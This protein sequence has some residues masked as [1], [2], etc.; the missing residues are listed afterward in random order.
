MVYGG[1][2]ATP[3]EGYHPAEYAISL[4]D[5]PAGTDAASET[6]LGPSGH[7]VMRGHIDG[8]IPTAL[9][10][11]LLYPSPRARSLALYTSV[12][13]IAFDLVPSRC[14]R[15]GYHLDPSLRPIEPEGSRTPPEF[16][17]DSDP[18][19]SS[20]PGL[21]AVAP[22]S[23]PL[24]ISAVARSPVGP[25]VAVTPA[26]RSGTTWEFA[27]ESFYLFGPGGSAGLSADRALGSISTARIDPRPV[28][29]GRAVAAVPGGVAVIAGGDAV[30]LSGSRATTILA[31]TGG[32]LLGYEPA[33][34]ELWCARASPDGDAPAAVRVVDMAR[35]WNYLRD[36][37]VPT[38]FC[39]TAAGLLATMDGGAVRD[40]SVGTDGPMEISFGLDAQVGVRRHAR[41]P[42][43]L[44]MAGRSL[45]GTVNV[46]ASQGGAQS[47][48]VATFG[49]DGDLD[50]PI[51]AMLALPHCH[52]LRVEARLTTPYPESFTLTLE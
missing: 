41:V 35:D 19:P 46:A 34:R 29:S 15:W 3:F 51:G 27:R 49:L 1:L 14:G 8:R 9:S 17:D 20:W 28:L 21:V 44:A 45:A 30:R 38:S 50:H 40:C 39:A 7:T 47:V 6:D 2:T 31:G 13:H 16:P 43:G 11:L 48:D 22:V 12:W 42:F 26:A 18:L 52:A 10:P 32:D 36:D 5:H 4:A 23:A 37:F 33:H 24:S 25:P